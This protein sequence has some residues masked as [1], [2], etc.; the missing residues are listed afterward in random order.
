MASLDR[1]RLAK[2]ILNERLGKRLEVNG[3]GVTRTSDGFGVKVNLSGEPNDDLEIPDEVD[4]V[5]VQVAVVGEI[6]KRAI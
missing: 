5:P 4:G 2:S 3:V 6:R 1:A